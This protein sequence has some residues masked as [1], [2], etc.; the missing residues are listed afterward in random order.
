M[1]EIKETDL[2]NKIEMKLTLDKFLELLKQQCGQKCQISAIVRNLDVMTFQCLAYNSDSL[3]DFY[4]DVLGGL[5]TVYLRIGEN[6][7]FEEYLAEVISH[8][9]LMKDN[10]VP[11]K[12]Q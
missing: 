1:A 7:D 10:L 2:G 5:I 8:L 4:F 3:Q 11:I 12:R 9:R 6:I